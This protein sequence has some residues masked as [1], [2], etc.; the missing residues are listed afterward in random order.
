MNRS[1]AAE[2]VREHGPF[3]GVEQVHGVSHD[4]RHVWF[5]SGDRLNALDPASGKVMC[6]LDA[7]TA[8][9]IRR[10]DPP[11]GEIKVNGGDLFYCGGGGSGR[12]RAVRRPRR[13][14]ATGRR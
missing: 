14:S 11:S 5:A 7:G 6:S 10:A 9:E 13:R 12:L 8:F 3:R 4:G 2:I 1:A